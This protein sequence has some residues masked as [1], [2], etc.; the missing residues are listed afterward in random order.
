VLTV[1]AGAMLPLAIARWVTQ[2]HHALAAFVADDESLLENLLTALPSFL[3]GHLVLSVP[4]WDSLPYERAR[5]SRRV[6]GTRVASL[7]SLVEAHA[8]PIP[9]RLELDQGASWPS[10]YSIRIVSAVPATRGRFVCSRPAKRLQSPARQKLTNR[11][12][13]SERLLPDGPLVSLF[14]F[15]PRAALGLM[16][17]IEDRI[18]GW[19]DLVR[20]SYAAELDAVRAGHQVRLRRTN[21]S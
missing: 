15:L 9:V 16:Q 17:N 14:D 10:G 1:S 12:P 7:A 13:A 5:P 11:P 19:L 6:A 3:P 18:A 21:Y 20:D 4:A 2:G 8:E